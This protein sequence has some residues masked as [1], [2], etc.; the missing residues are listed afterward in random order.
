[1]LTRKDPSALPPQDDPSLIGKA[2]RVVNYLTEFFLYLLAF[3]VTFANSVVEVGAGFIIFCFILKR[4]ILKDFK[5]KARPTVFALF[6][7]FAWLLCS[8]FYSDYRQDSFERILRWLR[9]IFVFL[10]LVDYFV[11]DE[12]RIKRFFWAFI[13]IA[14][15]T[16]I[17]GIF[18]EL[19]GF[20]ILRH[21]RTVNPL[22][23]M[24]RI[25]ASFVH[26]NDF[27]A[28]IIT[29]LP[30]TFVFMLRSLKNWQRALLIAACILGFYCLLKTSSRGA[31]VGFFVG[32]VIFASFYN[33]KITIAIPIALILVLLFVPGVR[34]RAMS[35]FSP[36][37]NTVWE[38][39]QLWQGTIAMIK[40]HPIKGFGLNTYS[41]YF[42]IYKPADYPDL[43]YAHNCFLQMWAEIGLVGLLIFIGI[44]GTVFITV[45]RGLNKK[46]NK[47]FEGLLITASLAGYTAYLVQS[48]L[49]TNLYSLAL[50]FH[51]WVLT[52][53]L[54]SVNKILEEDFS[55]EPSLIKKS[56]GGRL[57]A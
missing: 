24:H 36:E 7:Y 11:E 21:D 15:F 20:S 13:S 9:Y 5:F 37:H 33:K 32:I 17:N 6:L 48:A 45:I 18:Q 40:E 51:F 50:T 2:L 12:K 26:P 57:H 30:L 46:K 23:I 52:A 28:Y 4:I 14:V 56:Q 10:A 55:D 29:A 53:Y 3:G 47:G 41:K 19:T 43:R 44:I 22:D 27:G 8:L 34:S 49:D 31:W 35:L 16:F 38:R 1:M 39:T 42:P 54:I 25:S